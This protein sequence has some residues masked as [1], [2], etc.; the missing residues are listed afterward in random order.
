MWLLI[1]DCRIVCKCGSYPVDQVA[2]IRLIEETVEYS[3][4]ILSL[5]SNKAY[6][7]DNTFTVVSQPFLINQRLPTQ[8][9]NMYD[10]MIIHEH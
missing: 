1:I 5:L 7:K 10:V 4:T 2:K 9:V 8:Q 6:D 3:N